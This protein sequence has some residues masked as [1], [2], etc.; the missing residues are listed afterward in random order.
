MAL[1][2][3]RFTNP[4]LEKMASGQDYLLLTEQGTWESFPLF[5]DR[6]TQ[7]IGA[8]ITERLSAPDMH[9]WNISI[10]NVT[11]HLV[12]EDFPNG[13]SV[14]PKDGQGEDMIHK[15]F[16]QALEQRTPDGL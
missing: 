1:T 13:I 12:Y 14:E 3:L 8:I 10:D 6:Y 2:M 16:Q 15:L 9:L 11:L 7:Q 5:A 4:K